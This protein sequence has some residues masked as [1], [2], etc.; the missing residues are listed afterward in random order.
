[1]ML[2]SGALGMTLPDAFMR[3]TIL[4]RADIVKMRLKGMM[5]MIQ[6]MFGISLIVSFLSRFSDPVLL[7][8]DHS[9]G[10]CRLW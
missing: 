1:M 8:R 6:S 4:I 10:M 3:F 2:M 5:I 9:L 7:D